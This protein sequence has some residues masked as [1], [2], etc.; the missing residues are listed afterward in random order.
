MPFLSPPKPTKAPKIKNC[1]VIV[2]KN[3]RKNNT[4]SNNVIMKKFESIEEKFE[5]YESSTQDMKNA[6]ASNMEA[7]DGLNSK[8]DKISQLLGVLTEN[9]GERNESNPATKIFYSF[10]G[11]YVPSGWKHYARDRKTLR[12]TFF[13][14]GIMFFSLK[15]TF[16]WGFIL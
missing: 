4:L 1:K 6:L 16:S 14:P 5:S 11:I 8:L 15:D 13:S 10:Y 2:E 12:R 7:I 3:L 9:G